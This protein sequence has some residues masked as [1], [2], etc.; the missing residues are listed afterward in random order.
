M[1]TPAEIIAARVNGRAEASGAN[2]AMDWDDGS[3]SDVSTGMDGAMAGSIPSLAD[4]SAF[5]ALGKG[6]AGAS[7]NGA[8]GGANGGGW[9]PAMKP[10]KAASASS[11]ASGASGAS[12][13]ALA[14]AASTIQEAFSLDADDQLNVARPEFIKILTSVKADTKTNIECTT[15]QHTKKR[16]FLITGKPEDVKLAKRLVIKKLTKPVRASFTVPA[17]LRAKIIGP[18][19]SVLRP[20][21]G[22]YE[23]RVDIGKPTDS[24]TEGSPVSGADGASPSPNGTSASA[25]T[26]G[27]GS[28]IFDTLVTITIDGDVEGCKLAKNKIL[29]IVKEENKTLSVKIPLDDHVKPFAAKYL[30][31]VVE[32]YPDLDI[33]VPDYKGKDTITIIGERELVVKAREDIREKLDELSRRLVVE[34]VPIPPVKHQFLPIDAILAEE[35][36]LIKVGD[37][38]VQFIGEKDRISGAK[39]KA[40][41]TTS[42]FKV[43]VLDMSKAHKGN[44]AHVK[45]VADYLGRSGFF[46]TVGLAHGVVVKAPSK[47]VLNQASATTIPVQ[48][49]VNSKETGEDNVKAAKREIVA[50][51]NKLTPDSTKVIEDI[52]EFFL[53]R[54]PGVIGDVCKEL[55]VVSSVIGSRITLFDGADEDSGDDFEDT[56]KAS[57]NF[58]TVD[59]LLDGLRGLKA[60]LESVVLDIPASVQKYVQGPRNTTVDAIVAEAEPHSV[61]VKF[62]GDNVHINGVKSQVLVVKKLVEQAI[63]DA[64]EFGDKYTAEVQ[65]PS[66][67][68]SRLIGKNGQFMNGLK[69]DYGV[70]I[71]V[72]EED[73][74]SAKALIQL[75]GIKRNVDGCKAKITSLSK[76][77][78]DET[79]AKLK[80]ESQYHRRMI[81]PNAV[82]VTR[83]QEKYGV[84]IR[85]PP[86]ATDSTESS[87]NEVIIR[88]PSKAVASAKDELEQLYKF[89]KDNGFEQTIQVPTK[90]IAR[91]IGKSG[92]TINDIADATGVSYKFQRDKASEEASGVVEVKLTGT[93]S[94]LKD[95]KA[96]IEEIVAEIENFVSVDLDV[97]SKYHRDIIGQGGSRM[98]EI[99]AQAGGDEVPR[100][101]YYKLLSIP[102]EGSGSTTIN[103]QGPKEIVNKIVAQI[104]ALVDLKKASVVEEIAVAK[105]KHRF[106][107][108]PSGSTRQALEKEFNVQIEVPRAGDEST[109]VKVSGLP[110]NIE[111]AKVKVQELTKDAWNDSIDIPVEYF[112]FVSEKG[113]IFRT[114]KSGYHVDVSHDNLAKKASKLATA[115]APAPPETPDESET[116]KFIV[117]PYAPEAPSA[118]ATAIPFRLKGKKD[119]TSKVKKLLEDRL[120][121]A[122][123]ADSQAWYYSANPAKF[124]KLVGPQGATISD[125]RAKSGAFITVP[126]ASDK[127]NRYVYMVGSRESLEKA[128]GLI[129]KL[130]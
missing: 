91:V 13:V 96:K 60:S 85:F 102:N 51:V 2:G 55:G 117:A 58:E 21:V 36:V 99:L 76:K 94:G 53:P 50:H 31:N 88:G 86:V 18:G 80:V 78:A 107:V 100:S 49:V 23:V 90:A 124:S 64:E 34:E 114:L 106:L 93:K 30:D 47:S 79:S 63:K 43:E 61:V 118:G 75:V 44:L 41:Q 69:A 87:S 77:W 5:P 1:S 39:E 24:T 92:E 57:T 123:A 65:V 97:D 37:E 8:N 109:A 103:S 59:R 66:T 26:G 17:A 72:Q 116:T 67:V 115:L 38:S 25:S 70:K 73:N 89:E 129:K 11:S 128:E 9:G 84:R 82:Y 62:Q 45:A 48:I 10:A 3:D 74:D 110:E 33:F 32:S 6:G 125:L 56:S 46:D 119:Q 54:V 15:S 20:I 83:L 108:G 28:D 104:N 111:K 42:Q 35:N 16:T 105:E 126:R 98:R 4:E 113:A 121:L 52:D 19:G 68:L 120:E 40:R 29:A 101:R 130:I 71:D 112:G 7:A 81:G 14:V 95:A 12:A 127:E 22:E 27:A 122:K